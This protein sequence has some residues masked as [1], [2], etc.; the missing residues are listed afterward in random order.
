MLLNGF[1]V[2]WLNGWGELNNL[3]MQ[4]FSHVRM[5]PQRKPL[6]PQ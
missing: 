6:Q 5:Q 4:P 3:T 1:I 2:E